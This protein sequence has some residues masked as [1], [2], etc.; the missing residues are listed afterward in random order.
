VQSLKAS[1]EVVAMT[2]DGVN[3]A[4]ALKAAHIGIAMGGRGSDVARESAALVLTGDDFGSIVA[5][6]RIGRRI[7]ENIRN[8][9]RYLI[10]VHVPIAGAAFVPVLF[11]WPP[12]LLP[13]HVMF[14]EFLIDPAC[15]IAFEAEASDEEAMR[16][17]PRDPGARLFDGAMA[18]GAFLTGTVMLAAL[19]LVCS[20]AA[21]AGRDAD[22]WRALAFACI[23]FGNVGMILISRS[24]WRSIGE[25]ILRPNPALW[26][27]VGVALAALCVALYVP[28]AAALFRFAPPNLLDVAIAFAAVL[29][30]AVL[31]EGSRRW[32]RRA[33]ST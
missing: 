4:P 13:V 27:V 24:R 28:Q 5:A 17:P 16:R 32:R 11:G 6:I 30:G 33:S 10:A 3:D 26:T 7:Y 12:L 2:G 20:W 18:A 15:T 31:I 1:G 8:A 29:C 25:T 22:E 21:A 9:I 19:L 14:L 23:V